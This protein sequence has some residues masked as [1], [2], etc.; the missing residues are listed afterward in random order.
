MPITKSN[1][2]KASIVRKRIAI[3]SK[4][5]TCGK[6]IRQN[7]NQVLARSIAAAS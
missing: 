5:A 3:K 7:W 4:G 2:L 6:V 1:D